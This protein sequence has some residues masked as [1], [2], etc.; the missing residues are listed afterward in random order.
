MTWHPPPYK[1]CNAETLL[2]DRYWGTVWRTCGL[3]AGHPG[4]HASYLE[5]P[6]AMALMYQ[7]GQD[8]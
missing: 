8:A 2:V 4:D 6:S 7:W 5:A 3:I 1:R